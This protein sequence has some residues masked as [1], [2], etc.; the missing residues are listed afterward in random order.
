MRGAM[1]YYSMLGVSRQVSGEDLKRRYRQ[2]VRTAHPD[3]AADPEGAHE[4][5]ILLVEA[6]R[7]LS[8]PVRRR[9][10]DAMQDVEPPRR[11]QSAQVVE[12]IEDW[13]RHAV[14]RLEAGDLAA[15]SAQCRKILA[16]DPRHAATHAMMGDIHSRREE[17]DQALVCYSSAVSAAP[18][19]PTYAY[20]LRAAA[21]AGQQQRAAAERRE[22]AAAHRQRA[23]E[24]LNAKHDFAV[25]STL[26]AGAWLV[27]L[28]VWVL[29]DPGPAVVW[30]PLPRNVALAALGCGLVLG[31]VLGINRWPRPGDAADPPR[32]ALLVTIGLTLVSALQ[33]YLGLA[34]Y[35][36]LSFVRERLVP[37]FTVAFAASLALVLVLAGLAL[38]ADPESRQTSLSTAA[39]SGN[40]VLPAVLLGH[41]LGRLG[42]R[43]AR[44][45]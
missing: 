38:V 24:A 9:A 34:G 3:L 10:Y 26:L 33:F 21:G 22:R 32:R 43:P 2:L 41:G 19:N 6:Y 35:V 7:V 18:R 13:F 4:R 11:T 14:H 20:K 45:A 15:A 27:L 29:R 25:Y 36:L 42:L 30:L 1:D 12:Q 28:L 16:L 5:F 40:L 37:R 23:L 17:W 8:D 31:F 39:W 44:T